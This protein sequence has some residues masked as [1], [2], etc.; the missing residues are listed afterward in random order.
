MLTRF[1][2]LL[3]TSFLLAQSGRITVEGN[4]TVH[5]PDLGLLT[6]RVMTGT[7]TVDPLFTDFISQPSS[8]YTDLY[9]IHAL[10]N[11][12]SA[13]ILADFVP[14][15]ATVSRNGNTSVELMFKKGWNATFYPNA[16]LKVR[17]AEVPR[18]HVYIAGKNASEL[19][20]NIKDFRRIL[21][22]SKLDSKYLIPNPYF[23][24]E[25]QVSTQYYSGK[26]RVAVAVDA[27]MTEFLSRPDAMLIYA[28][29]VHGD[30]EWYN[31][32]M[33]QL[34]RADVQWLGLEMLPSS[35][36]PIIDHFCT[37]PTTSIDY[38][39]ARRQL[40]DYFIKAWTPYFQLNITSGEQSPYFHAVDLMRQK[41]GRVYGLDFDTPEFFL[42]RY[43][44]SNFGASVRNLNWAASVPTKGRG[45]IFGGS[46]HFTMNRSANV[47][48]F[49]V[50][51]DKNVALFSIDSIGPSPSASA[52]PHGLLNHFVVFFVC[53]AVAFLGH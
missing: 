31:T 49:L 1:C 51:R 16:I 6:L 43:G 35:M 44:E 7:F 12:T 33:A 28:D 45:I 3:V 4:R 21:N 30:L 52:A 29:S 11:F 14:T 22:E 13:Q 19:I 25:K 10:Q 40:A 9:G 20:D 39:N 17:I 23:D 50:I 34:K 42:F 48:D 32:F 18:D 37:A 15:H 5:E 24:V 27:N 47:Q 46:A 8:V 26:P 53:L 41:K 2:L 38:G 36:Q